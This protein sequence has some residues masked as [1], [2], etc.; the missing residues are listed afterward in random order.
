MLRSPASIASATWRG[1]ATVRLIRRAIAAIRASDEGIAAVEF[2][3]ILPL[4]LTM[5]F[6]SVEVTK[7][8]RGSSKVDLVANTLANISSQQTAMRSAQQTACNDPSA[9]C[10]NDADMTGSN[11]AFTSASSILSPFSTNTL[12]MTISQVNVSSYNGSLIAKVEWTVTNN[13]G[14][15]RPCIGGGV[16]N[17]LLPGTVQPGS[18]NYQNYIPANYVASGAPTGRMIIADVVYN[19]QPGFG[20]GSTSWST[21][22]T[23]FKMASV[24]YYRNRNTGTNA[25]F[26]ATAGPGAITDDVTTNKTHCP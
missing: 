5:Y 15:P 7:A 10:L 4:M 22:S 1:A 24:G 21:A 19:Y 26:P 6:G 3:L 20:F 14:T 9:P 12:Q 8:V 11:G 2:A 13:G 16:N 18:T 23:S 25:A 17:S